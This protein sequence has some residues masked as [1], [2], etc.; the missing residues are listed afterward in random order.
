MMIRRVVVTGAGCVTPLGTDVATF[1]HR[2]IAGD[3]GIG[4]ISQFD[5]SRF[6]VRIAAEVRDWGEAGLA[7]TVAR[8]AD[9][10]RQT[11]FAIAAAIQAGEQ[12]GLSPIRGDPTK[13]GVYLGCGEL[14]PDFFKISRSISES[15]RKGAFS[16]DYFSWRYSQVANR[17]DEDSCEP[18]AAVGLIAS[19]FDA[20]GPTSNCTTA[21]VSSSV[22]IGNALE[23]I[24]RG[25][26]DL[27]L[28]GGSHSM[29]HPLG[30]T[31]LCR[32]SV[33]STRN[34][35]PESAS[36]PF[37]ADRDGFVV[38]EG[39]AVFV[40]EELGHA[41]RRKAKIWGELRGFASTHDAYS[42]SAPHADGT[43]AARCIRL[44]LDDASL[45]PEDIDYINAHGSGTVLNDK[46]ETVAI[47]RALGPHAYHVPISSTKSM[48][49]HLTT[50]CGAIEMLA[51]LLAVHRG[52][53]PP[54]INCETPDPDC[55]L[56]YVPN[57][58]REIP[59]RHT[60]SNNSGFGGQNAS[61]VISRFDG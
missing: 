8:R 52:V 28:A 32:M 35:E 23:T 14:F 10:P 15:L 44:A 53:V 41:V 36:R 60:L 11:R 50:A 42:I 9:L 46:A 4:V 37:D 38:G 39:G 51:C 61:L 17:F 29:V 1:W 5:A 49:G 25:D 22:A 48:T 40:L 30:I 13:L 55:D 27:M 31:G 20:Q 18:G 54:T 56:D 2:L 47:K 7:T 43:T 19:L 45:N 33:L 3:T 58:A 6:P 34:A 24:R 12:A 21:C 16:R 59:C 26:A 57:I